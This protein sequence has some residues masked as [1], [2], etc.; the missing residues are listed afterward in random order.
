MTRSPKRGSFASGTGT[1]TRSETRSPRMPTRRNGPDTAT[2][3]GGVPYSGL[4]VMPGEVGWM[5]PQFHGWVTRE[6]D[7][8]RHRG[9]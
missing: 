8:E 6:D 4:I 3:A 5:T 9:G 7:P 1:P 2:E